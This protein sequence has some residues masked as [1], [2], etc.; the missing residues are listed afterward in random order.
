[1][2]FAAAELYMACRDTDGGVFDETLLLT[3]RPANGGNR[4]ERPFGPYDQVFVVPKERVGTPRL[5]VA[6][7][8][9]RAN[10][11]DC[12]DRDIYTRTC[13]TTLRGRLELLLDDTS[14][15]RRDVDVDDL[16]APPVLDRRARLERRAREVRV[17]AR[18]VRG[19]TLYIPIFEAPR[20]GRGRTRGRSSAA[21]RPLAVK[22]ATLKPSRAFQTVTVPLGAAAR[23][24]VLR[25]GGVRIEL[26]VD[27]PAGR[28]V[29]ATLTARLP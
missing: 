28:T 4:G 29:H 17:R 27:P 10:A 24:A 19:C 11:A 1:V 6:I 21:G 23:R 15:R 13:A 9:Q 26:V 12:P 20:R 3:N 7:N 5:S 16:L 18:C 14:E 22:R 25:A 8:N 2:P